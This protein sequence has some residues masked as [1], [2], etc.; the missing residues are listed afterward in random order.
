[1]NINEMERAVEAMLFAAGKEVP[2]SDIAEAINIDKSTAKAIINSIAEKYEQQKRGIRIVE[3]DNC[4]QMCSAPEYFEYVS[5]IC[6]IPKQKF[7]SQ[8]LLETL[9][10]IAYNQPITKAQI[11]DI[12]GVSAEHSVNKLVEKGLVVETGRLDAPG[13]PILFGTTKEFLRYFGL[14]STKELLEVENIIN[15]EQEV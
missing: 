7:I 9:S 12:R 11:E 8:S 4:F 3:I 2:L 14:K 6:K 1:M 10:I 13:K 5:C 15:E